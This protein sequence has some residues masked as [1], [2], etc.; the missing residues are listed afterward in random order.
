MIPDSPPV[1]RRT[2]AEV[3]V[4]L[5]KLCRELIPQWPRETMST[6][7]A[8]ALIQISSR[9]SELIIDRLNR[10][11]GKNFLAFLNLIGVSPIPAQAARVP[12]TFVAAPNAPG[13]VVVPA[14][15][16]VTAEAAAGESGPI[17]YETDHD[18]V[19]STAALESVFVKNP[20]ADEVGDYSAVVTPAH[21]PEL[22]QQVVE[23][24]PVFRGNRPIR[25]AFYVG[26]SVPANV[27]SLQSLRL[28]FTLEIADFATAPTYTLQWEIVTAHA[29]GDEF[30]EDYVFNID[31][32]AGSFLTPTLDDTANL[33]RGGDIVFENV[34]L[35]PASRKDDKSA[36][37]QEGSSDI[38]VWVRC[39]LMTALTREQL[40][41]DL[42]T[43]QQL[44]HIIG[45][46]STVDIGATSLTPDAGFFNNAKLDISREFYPFGEKPQFGDT[47][48]LAAGKAFSIHDAEITLDITL[49]NPASGGSSTIPSAA[50]NNVSLRWDFWDGDGWSE[51]GVSEYGKQ[52]RLVREDTGFA[53]STQSLSESGTI[54]FRLPAPAMPTVVNGQKGVWIR[55]SLIAGDFGRD[56]HYEKEGRGYI[57]V[58]ATYAPPCIKSLKVSYSFSHTLAPAAVFALNDGRVLEAEDDGSLRPFHS[59]ADI[60]PALYLG[61]SP[62]PARRRGLSEGRSALS[63]QTLSLYVAVMNTVREWTTENGP[64]DRAAS[65]AWEYWNGRT[66]ANVAVEDDTR[67]FMRSGTIR[68]LT[69]NDFSARREFG[70]PRY[71]LRAR[72]VTGLSNLDPC[73]RFLCLN[74][75]MA[76][77]SQTIKAELLG[78]SNGEP[79]QTYKTFRAPVL[80]GQK[81][82]VIEPV[83]PPSP[84]RET[85]IVEEGED[86]IVR[87]PNPSTHAEEVWVRW[88]EVANFHG[89]GPRDRHY[90]ID[91]ATGVITFG[92]GIDGLIPPR[93][94][95]NIHMACYRTGPGAASNKPAGAIKQLRSALPYVQKVENPESATGGADTEAMLDMLQRAP[96]E[97]RH[98]FRAVTTEDFEDLARIASPRVSRAKCV[99]L[100]DLSKDPDARRRHPA[101]VSLIVSPRSA[102]PRPPLTVDL[103]D[104]VSSYLDQYRAPIG[105]LVLVAPE[106]VR[107]DVTAEVT[108]S[109]VEDAAKM[110]GEAAKA[111][112]H[113]LHPSEGGWRGAGWEFG[114]KPRPS[115]IDALLH[116][117]RGVS[118]VRRMRV[119][120][121]GDRPGAERTGRFLIYSGRHTITVTI[122]Q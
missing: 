26:V 85:L 114:Q 61:F 59:S 97:I 47:F 86:A 78:S 83:M 102:D 68:I 62:G 113:F 69:P 67:G 53:D 98:R 11:P 13:N 39:C 115:D 34:P 65:T 110:Q 35:V 1:D 10:A 101:V 14:G 49:V 6:G 79:N 20:A 55:A 15:T 93:L 107:I 24:F 18:L 23:L 105:K 103:M 84:E 57:V 95:G 73:L 122:K 3:S 45:L 33:T 28:S 48:Y 108:A 41:Q 119:S 5:D 21:S 116:K 117:V 81:L 32:Q 71:W 90:V 46:T 104:Q 63:G 42:L 17:V 111:L 51:F 70:L 72:R 94:V 82:E 22:A 87:R 19:V 31:A 12:L 58:P 2:A 16:Q 9:Y 64:L 74:T 106:Y 27:L 112:E 40:R 118:H 77:G 109:T 4:Q 54:H 99:P 66:W 88:H 7:T 76:S 96:Q 92:D 37:P 60:E 121:L 38:V 91:H 100:H 43:P 36:V 30:G 89:S 120:M 8:E 50:P 75:T 25:H 80:L 52:V 44:P 56:A 29:P